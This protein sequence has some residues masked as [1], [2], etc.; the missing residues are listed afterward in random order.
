MLAGCLVQNCRPVLSLP[1]EQLLHR[2]RQFCQRGESSLPNGIGIDQLAVLQAR[3][4]IQYES[5]DQDDLTAASELVL[6]I[7]SRHGI[8]FA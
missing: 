3:F 8:A 2:I 4:S 1:R 6:W 5:E 7:R